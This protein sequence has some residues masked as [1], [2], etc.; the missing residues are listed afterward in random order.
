AAPEEMIAVDLAGTTKFVPRASVCWAE[1]Q[2]DY[3]RLQMAGGGSHLIRTPL[4]V[5]EQ[6]WEPAGFVRVHRSFLV[7]LNRIIELR[8][9][10]GGYRIAVS[11]RPTVGDLP[12]SRRHLRVLKQ[13]LLAGRRPGR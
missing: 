9:V 6:E 12:V 1:A 8:A 4:T 5:L 2:G 10:D 7:P 11:G 13:R 3:A